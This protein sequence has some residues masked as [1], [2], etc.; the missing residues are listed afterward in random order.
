MSLLTEVEEKVWPAWYKQLAIEQRS[1][2]SPN[3]DEY[4]GGGL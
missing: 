4:D 1:S 3:E 2:S